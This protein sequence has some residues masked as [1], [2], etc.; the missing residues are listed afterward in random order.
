MDRTLFQR[1]HWE[2][3]RVPSFTKKLK[4]CDKYLTQKSFLGISSE[5]EV[6]PV[7]SRGCFWGCFDMT[8]Q[9]ACMVAILIHLYTN[10]YGW[11]HMYAHTHTACNLWFEVEPLKA[12]L[13][14]KFI[15]S[16]PLSVQAYGFFCRFSILGGEGKHPKQSLARRNILEIIKGNNLTD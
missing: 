5:L 16:L 3:F 10:T 12:L 15:I 2:I 9:Q 1:F 11:V 6:V 13:I 7:I 14:G 4:F 8:P